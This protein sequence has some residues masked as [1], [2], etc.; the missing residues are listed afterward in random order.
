MI[1]LDWSIVPAIIIFV[2]TILALNYLLFRPVLRV[3]AEREKRTTGLMTQTRRDLDHHL[4][5][6]DQYQ[7]TIK[8]ARMEGYRLIEK[9]RSE[10]LLYRSSTLESGRNDAEQLIR[11]ARDSIQSQVLAAKV[12]LE[13]EAQEM[14][15]RIASAIL[16]RSA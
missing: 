10:A 13:Y 11:E 3:Q 1:S 6:F 5:L 12:R 9:A 4:Q 7:A 8:N 2:L 14:A 15:R 16:Q